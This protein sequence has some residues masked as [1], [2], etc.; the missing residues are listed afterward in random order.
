MIRKHIVVLGLALLSFLLLF[1]CSNTLSDSQETGSLVIGKS[2]GRALDVNTIK[3]A[4]VTITGNDSNGGKIAPITENV[5]GISGG[6]GSFI[7]NG[8]PIGKNRIVTVEGLD[9]DG[10]P[11]DGAVLRAVVDINAGHNTLDKITWVTSRKGYVYNALFENG[12]NISE[13]KEGTDDHI[14]ECAPASIALDKFVQDYKGDS[15]KSKDNYIINS[16]AELSYVKVSG[17]LPN[18][19]ATAYYTDGEEK[20]VTLS[21]V[22]TSSNK[23]C[24]TVDKGVVSYVDAGKT[25]ISVSYTDAGKT[26]KSNEAEVTVASEGGEINKLYLVPSPDWASANAWF[27]AYFFE[28]DAKNRWVKMEKSGDKYVCDKP[29]GYSTVIL[30]RMNPAKT[31]LSWDSKWNQTGDLLIPTDKDTFEVDVAT[32]WDETTKKWLDTLSGTYSGGGLKGTVE[33]ETIVVPAKPTVTI[34]PAD[35]K[36]V[37]LS[38]KIMVSFIANND[39]IISKTVK[40][41]GDSK[42]VSGN[43]FSIDV[44]DITSKENA[45]ITVEASATSSMG[46][47]VAKATITTVSEPDVPDTFT[48]DNVLCYFV[49]TDRFY[50]GDTSNDASYYRTPASKANGVPTV[51]L[52]HGGDIKGLTQKIDYFDNLGVNA[53]WI[54][55]PYEQAHGWTD[56]KDGKFPHYAFHGYYTLDWTFLDQNM[57][58]VDEF[59]EFVNTCHSRGIRVVMDVVMNHTGYF[60]MQDAM[61][62]NCGE[63]KN[64]KIPPNGWC[65]SSN[66]QQWNNSE[67]AL[68]DGEKWGNFWGK[69]VRAFKGEYGFSPEGT[70][71]LTGSLT[72]LPDVVTEMTEKVTIPAHLKTKWENELTSNKKWVNPSVENVDWGGMSGNWRDDNKGAPADYIVA[73]L[74]AW[75]REFGI[76]GFRCDTAKHVH[77][78]RWGQ[79]KKACQSALEAWRKDASKS[80]GGTGAK[81]W[82]ENFWMTGECFGW[83][84]TSGQGDYYTTGGFDSMINFSFNGSSGNTG[85]SPTTNDWGSYVNINKNGDSDNNGNRNSVLSYVSSH[86]TG[87]HRSTGAVKLGTYLGLLPGGVQIY[88]GD[89]SD[90]GEI[91]GLGDADM[92][93]RGDMNFLS[94]TDNRIKHW[95]KIGNFRKY[96]PAVGAG[97]GSAFKRSYSGPAGENKVAIGIN[98]TS[99]DVSGLFDNGTTVYNWYDG[100]SAQVLN[101]KATFSNGGSDTQ[102][103]LVSDKNPADF[104]RTF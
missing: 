54:T 103:I 11:I 86:D 67:Y 53:I 81:D 7:I 104:G 82:D 88:Y 73:W 46:T 79:L 55:A 65:P 40:I 5:I 93:T 47:T 56:G 43:S 59:R 14:P 51:A 92:K 4:K 48:W 72:G 31:A 16:A 23:D 74:S 30:C 8:I 32:Q 60:T 35:G 85:K 45:A 61:T 97:T 76:D 22:W 15:L 90:R 37:S 69:W 101:G 52:F 102:P 28:G 27:A 96:N 42:T 49:L 34:S 41:N 98:G 89:E 6:V 84:S 77:M 10:R 44:S 99:V 36:T 18:L 87:L 50:N 70:G 62:Y 91:D 94:D 66:W 39:A 33:F 24:A 95:S 3:T 80:D 38:G 17:D 58:T 12:V 26:V 78:F 100:S 25:T 21:G 68:T 57:G 20:D 71:E 29:S 13:V 9:D 83:T 63:F 64:N 19:T 75:V 1:G 2:D